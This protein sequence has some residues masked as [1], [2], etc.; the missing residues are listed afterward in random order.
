M[1]LAHGLNLARKDGKDVFLISTPAGR[2]LYQS[3]GFREVG[4]P[5]PICGTPHYPMLWSNSDPDSA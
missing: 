4:Q 5:F 1:L 2:G 3:M